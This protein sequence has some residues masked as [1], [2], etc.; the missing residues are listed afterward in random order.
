[1]SI[2]IQVMHKLYSRS[3]LSPSKIEIGY[4]YLPQEKQ[5]TQDIANI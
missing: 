3:G 1:M 5:N 2:N 4:G